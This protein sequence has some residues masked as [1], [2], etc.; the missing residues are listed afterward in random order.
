MNEYTLGNKLTRARTILYN[1]CILSFIILCFPALV[2]S[3]R[4]VG[5]GSAKYQ[6]K[7]IAFQFAA[8]EIALANARKIETSSAARHRIGPISTVPRNKTEP[9]P[10]TPLDSPLPRVNAIQA[11]LQL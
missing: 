1:T 3:R 10:P 5:F 11:S 6:T 9:N 8:R 7:E 2:S 4:F